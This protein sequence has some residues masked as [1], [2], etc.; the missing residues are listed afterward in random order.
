MAHWKKN[1]RRPSSWRLKNKDGS[2]EYEWLVWK[3]KLPAVEDVKTSQ[4]EIK[5]MAAAVQNLRGLTANK[6]AEEKEE[7][8]LRKSE[9]GEHEIVSGDEQRVEARSVVRWWIDLPLRAVASAWKK[10]CASWKRVKDGDMG[11]CLM[12]NHAQKRTALSNSRWMDEGEQ[13]DEGRGAAGT[14]V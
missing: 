5:L 13:R 1:W 12:V 7:C 14:A 4:A 2:C 3:E 11:Q 6:C 10:K 9:E 8:R